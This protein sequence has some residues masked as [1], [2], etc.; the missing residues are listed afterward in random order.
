MGIKRL[1]SGAGF[2]P[3]L[4]A[5]LFFLTNAFK[6]LGVSFLVHELTVIAVAFDV[7]FRVRVE[8]L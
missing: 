4:R 8:D 5:E 6:R 3:T 7:A 2:E 1:A